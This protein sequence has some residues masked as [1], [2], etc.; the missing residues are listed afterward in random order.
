MKNSELPNTVIDL[1]EAF[2][3]FSLSDNSEHQLKL[4]RKPFKRK[5]A[6]VKMSK[7]YR[8]SLKDVYGHQFLPELT[9]DRSA[10][11]VDELAYHSDSEI[12]LSGTKQRRKSATPL[13]KCVESKFP[14]SK[15]FNIGQYAKSQH[16]K[17]FSNKRP[18]K[19]NS[20]LSTTDETE[21]LSATQTLQLTEPC[22]CRSQSLGGVKSTGGKECSSS[23]FSSPSK[24]VHH[25]QQPKSCLTQARQA[26][27]E[28]IPVDDSI[29]VDELAAYFDEIVH[30]PRK[31]C[32]SVY[33]SMYA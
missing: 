17:S 10:S 29:S 31:M 9:T 13:R 3:G 6:R 23:S 1:S 12:E 11:Q 5:V 20:L 19:V 22:D 14:L 4:Q 27:A 7:I 33:E 18:R 8:D 24:C 15:S 2:S 30:L 28:I 16:T 21:L 25:H 26:E 32:R